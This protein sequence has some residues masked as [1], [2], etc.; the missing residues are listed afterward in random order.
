MPIDAAEQAEHDGFDQE[1]QQ[2]VAAAGADGQAQADLARP[3]GDRHQHDV[4]D[5]DA[6]D[7]Q[8]HAGDAREQRR[9][10]SASPRSRTLAIS[11]IVRTMKSSGSPG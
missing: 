6:A 3:L 8:R 1:L 9:S 10:S 4:H 5:A 11:S 7:E 2:H